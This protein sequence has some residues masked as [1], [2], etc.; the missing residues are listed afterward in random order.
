MFEFSFAALVMVAV[1][2]ALAWHFYA[3]Q[4]LGWVSSE[5]A[6]LR[7]DWAKFQAEVTALHAVNSARI[8]DLHAVVT[9]P[10]TNPVPATPASP[11]PAATPVTPPTP[12]PAA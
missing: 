10:A 3:T 1:L 12:P 5:E 7:A 8:T 9:S 6:V 11:A 2:G 4:I